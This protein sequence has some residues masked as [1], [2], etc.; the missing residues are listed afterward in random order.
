MCVCM[1][2]SECMDLSFIGMLTFIYML[3]VIE[4]LYSAKRDGE[5]AKGFEYIYQTCAQGMFYL[6][7]GKVSLE[8]L[9]PIFLSASK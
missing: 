8:I 3:S 2:L 9:L 5:R 6:L 1:F 7:D 4:M